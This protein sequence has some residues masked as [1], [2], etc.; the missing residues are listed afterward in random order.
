M[1]KKWLKIGAISL[2]VV[3]ILMIALPFIFKGRIVTT[4]QEQANANLN[5]KLHFSDV[6]LNLFRS[7]PNFSLQLDDFS[8]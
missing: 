6:G 8:I 5:A 2:G 1:G 3:I 7:F 4:I